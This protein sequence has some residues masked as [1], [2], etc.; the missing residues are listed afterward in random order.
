MMWRLGVPA[1]YCVLPPVLLSPPPPLTR[2]LLK[3][4]ERDGRRSRRAA[5]PLPTSGHWLVSQSLEFSLQEQVGRRW[6]NDHSR[7]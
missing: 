1:V 3:E 4:R 5:L 2:P 7:L 6:Y